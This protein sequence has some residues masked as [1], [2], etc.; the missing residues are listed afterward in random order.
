MMC[1]RS[2]CQEHAVGPQANVAEL[3]RFLKTEIAVL[4]PTSA[5]FRSD[6]RKEIGDVGAALLKR[7]GLDLLKQDGLI[8]ALVKL[9][10]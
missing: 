2:D 4:R 1:R 3:Q 5:N 7:G 8:T 9:L 10:L 6:L